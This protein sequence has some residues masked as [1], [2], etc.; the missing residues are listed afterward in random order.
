[1]RFG[2][3][4]GFGSGVWEPYFGKYFAQ[5]PARGDV[6]QQ[7]RNLLAAFDS[8]GQAGSAVPASLL[9]VQTGGDAGPT[10][11]EIFGRSIIPDGQG[12]WIYGTPPQYG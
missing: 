5:N 9:Q 8:A 4:Q 6:Y 10:A 2:G 11:T 3:D 7:A 1:M 12:G